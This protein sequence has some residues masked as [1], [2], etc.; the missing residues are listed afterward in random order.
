MGVRIHDAGEAP[1]HP[2]LD[3][4][5]AA[6]RTEATILVSTLAFGKLVGDAGTI[7]SF[8]YC[9]IDRQ[10]PPAGGVNVQV[11]LNEVRG[12][13]TI[14]TCV[15]GAT[16]LTSMKDWPSGLQQHQQGWLLRQ[17]RIALTKS[18][19]DG[20]L[21]Q[22]RGSF[23]DPDTP[24]NL[25]PR[26]GDRYRVARPANPTRRRGERDCDF[27]GRARTAACLSSLH[28]G[29]DCVVDSL[30]STFGSRRQHMK[31]LRAPAGG[32]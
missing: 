3:T 16:V 26:K 17:V 31:D 6:V 13:S 10:P 20:R 29:K 27:C 1:G 24:V 5:N 21:Y 15:I 30:G 14:A 32:G 11:Q 4:V 18:L 7:K 25:T 22:I 8:K 19:Q 12:N 23:Q 2:G 9:R 28:K